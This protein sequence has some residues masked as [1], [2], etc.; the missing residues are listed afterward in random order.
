MTNFTALPHFTGDAWQGGSQWPDARLGWV[1]LTA[2]GGHAGND[3]E[4]AAVR[5]WIAPRDGAVSISGTVRHE[6]EA[7]DGIIARIVSSRAGELG[8]WPLHNKKADAKV[9]RT[10]VQRGDTIDFVVDLGKNLNSDM[11][12]WA[13]VLKLVDAEA[14]GEP[15]QWSAKKDFGGPPPLP[16]TP[17]SPWEK[18]AQV[19]LQANEFWFVD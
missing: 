19:L 4:H 2:E 18:Y 17:L 12:K 14:V 5:R 11:F 15:P 1:Q 16:P 10:P 8:V 9:E 6:D 7:G 13:P 3:L